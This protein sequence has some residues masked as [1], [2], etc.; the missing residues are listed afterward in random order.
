MRW[1]LLSLV[2]F[3]CEGTIVGPTAPSTN[4]PVDPLDPTVPEV[5]LPAFAPATLRPRLLLGTQY[6]N[7]VTDLLGPDAARPVVPPRDVPVNGLAAVGATMLEISSSA[8]NEYESNAYLAASAA[9]AARRSQLITCTPSSATDA[10]CMHSIAE[11]F[12][13]RAF[14]R[15]ASNDELTRWTSVGIT[16]ATAYDDFDKGVEFLFA[17][18]LQSPAF[19]YIDETGEADPANPGR[20]RLTSWELATRLSFFLTNA[21]PDDLLR[22]A[23]QNGELATEAG[24]RTQAAR[25]LQKPEARVAMTALFDEIFE[26]N[27]LD[28]LAKDAV[29]FPNFDA[30]LGRSMKE[31]TRRT[32]LDLAFDTPTDF[33]DMFTRR[34]TFVDGPLSRHYGMPSA[35]GWMTAQL[36]P[37]RAGILTQAS[38]LSLMSHPSAN[39]PTYRGRFI[40]EKLL[41]QTIPA[42]PP[43]VSTTLPEPPPNT[44]RTLRQKVEL[45]MQ[46]TACQGCHTMMDPPG[47]AFEGFDATGKVQ[48]L[49]DGLPVDTTGSFEDKG[50]FTDAV[51]LAAILR[52]DTRVMSCLTRVVFRQGTGHV[53]LPTEARP[54]RAASEAFAASGYRYQSLLVEL[55]ASEAFRSGLSEAP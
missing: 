36:P 48:T 7:A 12:V 55:A 20:R 53:D 50:S 25:L 43:E 26:L 42:P 45:H 8:V 6:V 39:S 19:L 47:F 9:L 16:A 17:G 21:P 40:R 29:K 18:L 2:F 51:G 38:F 27:G 28:H 22:T 10:T 49:D 30:A 23:A 4:T 11:R 33:R 24:I 5:E 32:L 52:E 41:C 34:T 1:L 15:P 44:Q 37:N 46:A 3:G 13:P 14:R 35:T 54:L 31:E